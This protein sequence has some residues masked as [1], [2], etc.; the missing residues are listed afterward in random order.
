METIETPAKLEHFNSVRT[1]TLKICE[2]LKN[3]DYVVQ[4]VFDASPPK[5]VLGHTTWFFENFILKQYY[6]GYELYNPTFLYLF[7]SY[8][9]SQGDR[10]VRTDRGTISRP[11]VDEVKAYR[12][13][14]DK[15]LNEFLESDQEKDDIIY[16]FL[17]LGLQHEQQHQE[18]LMTDIKS[19]LGSNPMRPTYL[20]QA[21]G[22]LDNALNIKWIE[23]DEGVYEVGHKGNGFCFDN[24]L[25]AHKV[26]LHKYRVQDRVIT[27]GEYLE[28]MRDGGYENYEHWL[29]DGWEWKKENNINSPLYW[30][31]VDGKWHYYS[32]NGMQEIDMS[33]PVTHVSYF[34]ANA[35]AAWAGYRLPTEFEW[36]IAC[37]LT[38]ADVPEHANLLE[39][40]KNHPMP[41]QEGNNQFYGDVW[42]WTQSAYLPYPGY[43]REKGALGEYNGKFM[44][45]QMVLRGGSCATPRSHIR[46]TYRNFFQPELRWQFT[47]IRLAETL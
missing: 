47:G 16:T 12:A 36:E 11:T 45:N 28:F 43:K 18:L 24:E 5:W 32:L 1:I 30:E 44:I 35:Y 40:G 13:H 15:H 6:K 25:G 7:N 27:N 2:P 39:D 4:P 22:Y 19:I 9:E 21:F 37:K 33:S 29:A 8:Y 3:E 42:E 17:D 34:E 20:E 31:Y 23:I 10:T 14:V 26:Y 38:E 41:K 46:S